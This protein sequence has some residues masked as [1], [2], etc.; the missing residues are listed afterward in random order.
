[1]QFDKDSKIL[2]NLDNIIKVRNTLVHYKPEDYS[3]HSPFISDNK[4]Q[5][6]LT[7]F[8][9]GKFEHSV[10]YKNSGNPFFPHKCLGYGFSDWVLINTVSFVDEFHS[11]IVS[12]Q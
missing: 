12:A 1:M 6:E 3:I 11:M 9:D 4:N 2:I 8:L 5:Y 10:F 7:A